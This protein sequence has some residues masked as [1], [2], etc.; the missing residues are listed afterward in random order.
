MRSLKR[1]QGI[2]FNNFT[3]TLH[4]YISSKLIAGGIL[5]TNTVANTVDEPLSQLL[6]REGD[7]I[8]GDALFRSIEDG[9]TLTFKGFIQL[10]SLDAVAGAAAKLSA[11][12]VAH[13]WKVLLCVFDNNTLELM[14]LPLPQPSGPV[15]LTTSISAFVVCDMG[16]TTFILVGRSTT[17]TGDVV[18]T[19]HTIAFSFK[20]LA[21][22]RNVS[23]FCKL[24]DFS[25]SKLRVS[26]RDCKSLLGL[27]HLYR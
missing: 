21:N 2:F 16:L 20:G 1:K 26:V 27:A 10:Y 9:N 7:W 25:S 14:P 4:R 3:S 23:S 17:V 22:L 8:E 19:W 11:L 15:S 13:F 12:R 24:F 18:S 6:L 5:Y